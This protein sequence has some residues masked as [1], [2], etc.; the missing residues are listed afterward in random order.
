MDASRAIRLPSPQD[1]MPYRLTEDGALKYC[2]ACGRWYPIEKF[3]DVRE[4]RFWDLKDYRCVR[5]SNR[6]AFDAYKLVY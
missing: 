3:S 6:D 1:R 2:L 4:G 5:C